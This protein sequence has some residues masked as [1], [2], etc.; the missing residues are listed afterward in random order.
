LAQM[1]LP[2]GLLGGGAGLGFAAGGDVEGAQTGAGL[3][4][5]A[6]AALLLGGTRRG[7][8][9]LGKALFDRGPRAEMLGRAVRRRSGLLGSGS[10]PFLVTDY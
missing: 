2:A 10:L 4:A 1:A 7:Q 8:G 3:S 5:A 6:T 9:A